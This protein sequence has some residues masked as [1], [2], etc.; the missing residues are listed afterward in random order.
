MR[1]ILYT[2]GPNA[3]SVFLFVTLVMGGAAALTTGRAIALRWRTAAQLPLAMI[4]LA[5][6]VCFLHYSLFNEPTI[7]LT[8]LVAAIAHLKDDPVGAIDGIASAL[9]YLFVTFVILTGF[10]VVGFGLTRRRQMARQYH[11]LADPERA[12]AA[13]TDSG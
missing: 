1:G 3:F 12:P 6:T 4:P 13:S 8:P 9:H 10:A 7:A 11:W 5:L 2:G